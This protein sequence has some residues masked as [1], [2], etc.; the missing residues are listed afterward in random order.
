MNYEQALKYRVRKPIYKIEW[1]DK[2]QNV[3]DEVTEDILDGTL[4]VELKNGIRR[5]CNLTLKNNNK[6]YIPNEDG[7]VWISNRF[8]LYSG[9][10]V[11]GVPQY[12]PQGIYVL[13][14]PSVASNFS[15]KTISIEALD[16]FALLNG[17]LAGTLEADYIINVG[18]RISSAVKSII[19][20]AGLTE[21]K[22]LCYPTMQKSPYTLV[23]NAGQSYADMLFNLADMINYQI[24]FDINGNLVFEPITNENTK[25]E[26]WT[27]DSKDITYLGSTHNYDFKK[28]KNYCVVYGDNINGLQLKGVAEDTNIF[29]PTNTAK[30]GKRTMVIE[31]DIIYNNALA[32]Q[33][34]EYELKNAIQL[35]ESVDI[36]SIPIDII[37]EGDIILIEDDSNGL[38][39]DRYLVKNINLPLS[40]D[41]EMTMSVWKTRDIITVSTYTVDYYISTT[42][43]DSNDGL[44]QQTPCRTWSHVK[45]LIPEILD[46]DVNVYFASGDYHTYEP[47]IDIDNL[48]G[49]GSIT[50]IGD[51]DNPENYV[52]GNIVINSCTCLVKVS[53]FTIMME[54][55]VV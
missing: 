38:N 55:G 53:G 23:T 37:Q 35:Y 10:I 4:S 44:T 17:E 22:V 28:M 25:G 2:N 8:K 7:L 15:E 20:D 34:A 54:G 13:G 40:Y 16:K 19:T 48:F 45:T 29:S 42:G 49:I 36:K 43:S 18:T 11:D 14:N 27:F 47:E 46:N 31:D 39:R 33:R 52:L 9:L 32:N 1:M 30:I 50:F 26:I 12:N 3:V 51:V 6:R 21:T 5:T 24:Y 41:A